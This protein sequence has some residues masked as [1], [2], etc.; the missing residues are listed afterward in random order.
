MNNKFNPKRLGAIALAL[1]ALAPTVFVGA[2]ASASVVTYE[3]LEIFEVSFKVCK[4]V[5]LS[6]G[7]TGIVCQAVAV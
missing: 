5:T 4:E 6:P 7:V 1:A 3:V 2:P